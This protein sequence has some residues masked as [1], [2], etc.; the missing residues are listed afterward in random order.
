[1]IFP[2]QDWNGLKLEKRKRKT[3][4]SE[5]FVNLFLPGDDLDLIAYNTSCLVVFSSFPF[6]RELFAAK[7]NCPGAP[8]MERAALWPAFFQRRDFAGNICQRFSLYGSGRYR[9]QKKA[10]VFMG[11]VIEDFFSVSFFKDAA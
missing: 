11:R 2:D 8:G 5:G 6:S 1:M 9:T 10:G 3:S 7:G 4:T